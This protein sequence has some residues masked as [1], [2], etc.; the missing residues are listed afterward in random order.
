MNETKPHGNK[1]RKHSKET[2]EKIAE[3][4]RKNSN[5]EVHPELRIHTKRPKIKGVHALKGKPKSEAHKLKIAQSLRQNQKATYAKN[6]L[7]APSHNL[8]DVL[9]HITRKVRERKPRPPIT[10]ETRAKIRAAMA[11]NHNA[12]R[13]RA[14]TSQPTHNK[15]MQDVEDTD[16]L[17]T[18]EQELIAMIKEDRKTPTYTKP[19][20]ALDN[21][22][23]FFETE[24]E[25]QEWKA[26]LK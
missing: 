18:L 11:G 9:Q 22:R 25:F 10:E 20:P 21:M 7:S 5:A 24:A 12:I 15:P 16:D 3:A 26:T 4:M 14:Y 1:G 6:K 19:L 13:E 2:R 8:G 23:D 17:K